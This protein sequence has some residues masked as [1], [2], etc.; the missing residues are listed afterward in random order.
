MVSVK[1]IYGFPIFP[2]KYFPALF[3]NE[4]KKLLCLFQLGAFHSKTKRPK[5]QLIK[6]PVKQTLGCFMSSFLTDQFHDIACRPPE[7]FP[8]HFFLKGYLS[9]V[10][11]FLV[12]S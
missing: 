9:F 12:N 6:R 5:K 4:L 10:R 2:K 11:R 1:A 8:V 7:C 3:S